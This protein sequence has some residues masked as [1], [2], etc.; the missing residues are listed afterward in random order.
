[1]AGGQGSVAVFGGITSALVTPFAADRSVDPVG[2]KQILRHQRAEGVKSFCPLGGTGEPI[3]M[4]ADERR[5]VVDTVM[6]EVG[7]SATVIVGCLL[8]S[9]PEIIELAR[10]SERAGADAIM[11]IPPYFVGTRPRHVLRHLQAIATATDLPL[12]LFNG[13]GRAGVK[14]DAESV[15][16]L[17]TAVPNLVG[18][19]EAT[20]DM[21]LATEIAQALPDFALLQGLDEL[22]LPTLS[23]GGRGGIVSL[24]CLIPGTL[25]RL[26]GAFEE[27]DLATARALQHRILPL[28]KLIYAEPNPG[29]L[30]HAMNHLGLPGGICRPP[31]YPP[32]EAIVEGLSSVLDD[33]AA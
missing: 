31:L 20:G 21:V 14:L 12:I 6:D 7:G 19:K 2:L 24:A 10:Y 4:T 26:V 22:L 9:Q 1:M 11:A 3:S 33:F 28:A 30:K 27:G 23:V 13:P 17:A 25:V 16:E 32:A 8:P 18:I 5:L 15:V 29:P